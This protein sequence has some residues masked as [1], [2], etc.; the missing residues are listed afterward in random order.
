MDAED[1]VRA[2]RPSLLVEGISDVLRDQREDGLRWFA[3]D[4]SVSCEMSYQ[5][6]QCGT[7]R[8]APNRAK[9]AFKTSFPRECCLN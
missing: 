1:C 9:H 8:V 5:I 6:V 4:E 3:C 2:G 7:A